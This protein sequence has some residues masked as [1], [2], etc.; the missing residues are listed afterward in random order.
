MTLMMLGPVH[1]GSGQVLG[2]LDYV[3][4]QEKDGAIWFYAIDS[5]RMFSQLTDRQ[6]VDLDAA[7]RT[8][9]P[10]NGL[11]RIVNAI[12][13]PAKHAIW[14]CQADETLLKLC[15]Q[16]GS[17]SGR[18][19]NAD[20]G[21]RG[22]DRGESRERVPEPPS[23]FTMTRTGPKGDP[24]LPG[25]SVKGAIRTAWLWYRAGAG[26]VM[27]GLQAQAAH[28]RGD[29]FEAEV[30]G[31]RVQLGSAAEGIDTADPHADPLRSLRVTDAA[32]V[33]DS[34]VIERVVLYSGEG[35]QPRSD[36]R[37]PMFIDATFSGLEGEPIYAT[38]AV[39][40]YRELQS[41]KVPEGLRSEAGRR[42]ALAQ[43][44]G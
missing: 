23:I 15:Q 34:N 32:L 38:G 30:L 21:P 3:V 19:G 41:H 36:K 2:P 44:R 5:A 42:L 43:R 24:Y 12:F 22:G 33:P 31:Y 9:N 1:T 18:Q 40:I 14:Q 13:D 17:A 10:A 37:E 8:G 6:R 27:P 28:M 20:R 35:Q 4:R 29:I 7:T 16:T 25:S 11:R 39:S 26:Q